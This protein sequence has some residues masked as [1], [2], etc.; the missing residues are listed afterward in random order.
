MYVLVHLKTYAILLHLL[1]E[2][3][4]VRVSAGM[5]KLAVLKTARGNSLVPHF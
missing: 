5:H 3:L 2:D 1:D 4:A